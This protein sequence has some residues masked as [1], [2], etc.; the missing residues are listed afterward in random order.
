M[1]TLRSIFLLCAVALCLPLASRASIG[2]VNNV[3][4][5]GSSVICIPGADDQLI[6]I[7]NNGT[8][9]VR[10]SFDGGVG[11]PG[12]SP[13]NNGGASTTGVVQTGKSGTNPTPSTGYLLTG[14]SQVVISTTPY[15]A[16]P[17]GAV[18]GLHKP[19]VAILVTTSTTLDIITD[20]TT[21]QFPTT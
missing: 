5:S 3:N 4:A 2:Q 18:P 19:I 1:K 9:S 8:T 17:G 13:P 11:T 10:L 15:S 7:Q 12:Y 16:S 14:G 6:I 20:G 21:T